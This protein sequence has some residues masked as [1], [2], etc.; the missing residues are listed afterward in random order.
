MTKIEKLLFIIHFILVFQIFSETELV[1]IKKIIPDIVL[2]IRYATKNN[3]TGKVLYPSPDCFVAKEVAL[4]LKK[5]NE[6]LKKQGY[7]LKIFDGYRPLSIQK[8][9]WEF[10]PDPRF[11]A[12]PEKGSAHNKGYAVDVSLVDLN[13]ND[14]LMPTDYDEFSE[15]ANPN[16]NGLP[17]LALKHRR[18]L[19]N[20]MKKYGF[21]PSKTEW[22][23]FFYPGY[24][25]KPNLDI[26][27]EEL[28]R[29][30]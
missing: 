16:Y 20:T 5:V 14:V 26:S 28:K 6:D 24:K 10:L 7:K 12:N 17:P 1:N 8:I 22:W 11:I 30:L 3:F 29:S 15:R 2:D 9:L 13:G 25:N 19:H 27:F 4:S 23:H 18:I 21:I